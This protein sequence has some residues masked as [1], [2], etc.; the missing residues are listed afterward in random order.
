MIALKSYLKKKY[1]LPFWF[2]AVFAITLIPKQTVMLTDVK[3]LMDKI[4]VASNGRSGESYYLYLVNDSHSYL[5]PAGKFK[6]E[7]FELSNKQGVEIELKVNQEDLNKGRS[8]VDVYEVWTDKG[9]YLRK[10]DTTDKTF[11]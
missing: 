1:L 10:E 8:I 3:G 4:E 11:E 7:V 5:I 6:R 2:I 9:P